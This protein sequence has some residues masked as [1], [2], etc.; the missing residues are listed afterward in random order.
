MTSYH[1]FSEI[2]PLTTA[3][4][5]EVGFMNLDQEILTKKP[6]RLA[7]GIVAGLRCYLN[8]EGVEA[9]PLP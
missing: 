4:I 2:D 9:T 1:A 6:E 5:I 3:A 8:N 7:D